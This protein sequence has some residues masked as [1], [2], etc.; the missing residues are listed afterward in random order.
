LSGSSN[1]RLVD[2]EIITVKRGHK[3][4]AKLKNRAEVKKIIEELFQIDEKILK[5]NKKSY[6][7]NKSKVKKKF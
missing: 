3:N 5:E 7:L 2:A 4:K 6:K 1:K